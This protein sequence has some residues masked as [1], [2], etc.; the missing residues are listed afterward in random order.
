VNQINPQKLLNS[1]WTAIRPENNE[2]HFIVTKIQFDEQGIV[3]VCSIE[4]VL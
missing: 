2:K 3:T 4:S 1:K